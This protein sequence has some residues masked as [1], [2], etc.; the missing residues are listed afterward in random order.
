MQGTGWGGA[1]GKRG[2]E[3]QPGCSAAQHTKAKSL[4][5]QFVKIHLQPSELALARDAYALAFFG[6]G[7][8]RKPETLRPKP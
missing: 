5:P 6:S 3:F 1:K 2:V 4:R 7:G 8:H